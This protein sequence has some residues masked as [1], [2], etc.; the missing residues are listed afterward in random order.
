MVEDP[1]EKV[2]TGAVTFNNTIFFTSFSPGDS[3]NACVGGVGVNRAYAVDACNGWPVYNLDAS[4]EPGPL[5][6]EDRFR[7]LNQAGIAAGPM[8]LIEPEGAK[9]CIGLTCFDIGGRTFQRT[10]WTAGTGKVMSV[11]ARGRGFTLIELM[12]TVAI[13]AIVTSLAVGGYRQYLRRA[14]RVDATSALLTARLG[15]G[16]VLRTEWPIRRRR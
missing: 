8:I 12:I 7:T 2:L 10:F 4:T 6:L 5:G 15:R 3:I 14:A 11:T 13:L 16:K 1:G 9:E